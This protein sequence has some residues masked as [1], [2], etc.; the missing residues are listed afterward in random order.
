MTD[1]RLPTTLWVEGVLQHLTTQGIPFYILNKGAVASGTVLLKIN[2]RENGFIALQQQ[3]DSHGVMGWLRLFKD[4]A[5]EE[6]EI[7]AY[8]GRAVDR[9]PDVW[10]IEIEDRTLN[11]PFEGKIF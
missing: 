1:D 11:N 4:R 5:V 9:D 8:I 10:A 3:R 6:A 7:D 2:G